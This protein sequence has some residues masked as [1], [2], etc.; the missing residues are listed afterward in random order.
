MK[1]ITPTKVWANLQKIADGKTEV[2]WDEILD[3]FKGLGF[4]GNWMQI[5]DVVQWALDRGYWTRIKDVHNER[6]LVNR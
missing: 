6:Y 1:T 5:R 3:H 4:K 2:N